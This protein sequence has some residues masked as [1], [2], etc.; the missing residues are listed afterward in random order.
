MIMIIMICPR[1]LDV[2]M[3]YMSTLVMGVVVVTS[4]LQRDVLTAGMVGLAI[5]QAM[6]V[7]ISLSVSLLY[8]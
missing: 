3:D 6:D 1:W 4:I 5:T 7:S 2:R 8:I